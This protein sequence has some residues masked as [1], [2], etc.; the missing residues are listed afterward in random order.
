MQKDTPASTSLIS[1]FFTVLE[2]LPN[3]FSLIFLLILFVSVLTYIV[4]AGE[5]TR[6]DIKGFTQVLPNSYHTITNSPVGLMDILTAFQI[7]MVQSADIIF[8]LFIVGGSFAMLKETGAI[9]AAIITILKKK[10]RESSQ[11]LVLSALMFFFS[12]LGGFTGNFE[13]ILALLPLTITLCIALGYDS[14]VGV[15]MGFFSIA[16]GFG[17]APVNPFTLGVAQ[18]IAELPILSGLIFRLILWVVVTLVVIHFVLSYGAKVKADPTKSLVYGIDFSEYNISSKDMDSLF[19]TGRRKIILI[20]FSLFFAYMMYGLLYLDWDINAL[21]GAFLG[22]GI[23][24]SIIYG[25]SISKMGEIFI[26]GAAGMA[27]AALIVGASR[28]IMVILSE[29][30]I[31]DTMINVLSSGLEFFPTIIAAP[32]MMLAISFINI[33]IPSTSGKVFLTMPILLAIGDII[34]ITRQTTVLIFQLGDGIT[35]I[36]IPTLGIVVAAIAQG[37]ISYAKWLV[38]SGALACRLFIIGIAA[39]VIAVLIEWG[40]F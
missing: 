14:V 37:K 1:R 18:S 10:P 31:L 32:L 7:G 20:T 29:G 9:E 15:A 36:M 40:P 27:F 28:G 13:V 34:G 25:I 3:T 39:I 16:V 24:V 33:F 38:F 4:P 2:R 35:N 8:F 5:F 23:L 17:I 12:F 26:D 11:K 21:S 30:N 6:I 22:M 19:L